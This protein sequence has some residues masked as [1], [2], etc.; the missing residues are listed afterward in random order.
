MEDILH[1]AGFID[2]MAIDSADG[3]SA[4]VSGDGLRPEEHNLDLILM[5]I[6]MPDVNGFEACRLM[7]ASPRMADVPIIMVTAMTDA[8]SLRQAFAAGAIDYIRKPIVAVEL[9]ARVSTA[10]T[11]MDHRVRRKRRER[12]LESA[13]RELQTLRSGSPI[14]ASC[15]RIRCSTGE[16]KNLEEYVKTFSDFRV[17]DTICQLCIEQWN[18]ASEAA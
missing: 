10:L 9:V 6:M 1:D 17:D 14:C 8:D 12:E 13:L 3:V 7:K 5:D 18:K 4:Y 11:M 16:W 2:T 15:K